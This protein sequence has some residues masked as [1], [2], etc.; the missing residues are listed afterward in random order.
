MGYIEIDLD[1]LESAEN[2]AKEYCEYYESFQKIMHE[3]LQNLGDSWRGS[4]AER[5]QKK[6]ED[7]FDSSSTQQRT[8][9][10]TKSYTKY[11]NFALQEY[12]TAQEKCLNKAKKLMK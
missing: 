7:Y 2:S 5:F 10:R 9:S 4:D 3:A 11:L 1:C 6:V 8:L 12:S